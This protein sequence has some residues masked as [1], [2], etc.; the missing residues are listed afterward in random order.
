VTGVVTTL[1]LWFTRPLVVSGDGVGYIKRLLS[2]EW[3]VVPGHLIYV[4]LQE[5]LRRWLAPA[6]GHGDAASLATAVSVISGGLACGLLCW[7]VIRMAGRILPGLLAAA[8][9]AISYGFYRASCDVEAYASATALLI[10]LGC[11]VLPPGTTKGWPTAVAAGLLLGLTTLLHT[12][13]VLFTPFV[14]AG[15]WVA[16]R[17]WRYAAGAVAL[18]GALSL[19]SFLAVAWGMLGLTP[20][21]TFGWLMSSDNGYAQAPALSWS[22]IFRN[23]ARLVY[24]WGRSLIHSP[25]PDRLG[26][27]LSVN[28]STLGIAYLS[29]AAV[30]C[31]W[32]W[33]GIVPA[34]RRRLLLLWAW[35]V[36]LVFFGFIFF[37]AATERWVFV[38]PVLWLI[39]ALAWTRLWRWPAAAWVAG[40]LL[41]ALPLGANI[42]TVGQ[43]RAVDGRTLARSQGISPLLRQGDLLMYP[44]HTWDEYI[45]FYEDTPVERFILASFAGEE[46]GDREAFLARLE[47][48][49]QR[50][51]RAGGRVIAVR[52]FDPPDSHHGW[53]LLQALGV[54]RDDVL[55][56]L[57]RFEVRP[58]TL[59]PVGVW[60]VLPPSAG[61]AEVAVRAGQPE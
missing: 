49:L 1:L 6:G 28:R 39:L 14:F 8:G 32:G 10:A 46:Q 47:G 19:G 7:L 42:A 48:A 18:A 25:A 56:L 3:D 33:R 16:T 40:L 11:L 52:V 13:L 35:V 54:A 21:E 26:M 29:L 23:F 5:G 44:G 2:P 38:L 27:A 43:E 31:F 51:H 17:S 57:A 50:T 59:E 15:V 30:L 41:L 45:G 36:P 60:E 34:L 24:G 4:P 9:L 22:F 55:A 58:L 53:S 37:P 20:T 12:S 61:P